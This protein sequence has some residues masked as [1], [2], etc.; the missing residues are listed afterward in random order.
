M[1]YQTHILLFNVHHNFITILAEMSYIIVGN[2]VYYV[3][4]LLVKYGAWAFSFCV[5]KY[6]G[7]SGGY[8]GEWIVVLVEF[9]NKQ[10]YKYYKLSEG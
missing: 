2:S 4:R 7:T 6:I 10:A 1:S 3:F 8:L 9:L 5:Y